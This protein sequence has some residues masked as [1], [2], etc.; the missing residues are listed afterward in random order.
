M[1]LARQK[2]AGYL[3]VKGIV[4]LS[5]LIVNGCSSLYIVQYPRL[6]ESSESAFAK[7]GKE[8]PPHSRADRIVMIPY[9]SVFPLLETVMRKYHIKKVKKT[10][11][12]IIYAKQS[13]KEY[14][15]GYC[16]ENQLCENWY[17]SGD[18]IDGY[19]Y[20]KFDIQRVYSTRSWITIGLMIQTS[21][22]VLE[23]SVLSA[24]LTFGMTKIMQPS[25]TAEGRE[26]KEITSRVRW[27]KQ[28]A[29]P[30]KLIDELLNQ[31]FESALKDNPWLDE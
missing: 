13:F 22:E 23:P 31:Y 19:Y 24:V 9:D 29:V 14:N 5:I 8:I 15:D 3:V 1:I 12:G 10:S 16:R 30:N 7:G 4:L 20:Y 28:T 27:A 21:C 11:D 26:C 6:F 18:E 25:D 2:S 17:S